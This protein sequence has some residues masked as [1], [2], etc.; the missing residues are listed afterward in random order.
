MA[1]LQNEH[2]GANSQNTTGETEQCAF[3]QNELKD[4]R[5]G[6]AERLQNGMFANTV[7]HRHKRRRADE[8]EHQS[9]AGV[10]KVASEANELREVAQALGLKHAFGSRVGCDG[11]AAKHRV[12]LLCLC[13]WIDTRREQH[14]MLRDGSDQVFFVATLEKVEMRVD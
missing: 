4:S 10:R 14:L 13:G 2:R 11:A 6:E 8:C 5:P 1:Q 7:L 12:D 3:T 9:D